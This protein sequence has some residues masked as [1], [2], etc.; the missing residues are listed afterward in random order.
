M[1]HP[2][3]TQLQRNL[4]THYSQENWIIKSNFDRGRDEI[5]F[6]LPE[7]EDIKT[8]YTN[9]YNELSILPDIDHPR[10]RVLISFCHPDGSQYCSKLINPNKQDEINLALLGQLPTRSIS[11]TEIQRL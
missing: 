8:I 2:Y 6:I 10:E 11:E 9:L 1:K 4:Q 5:L 7:H 3:K